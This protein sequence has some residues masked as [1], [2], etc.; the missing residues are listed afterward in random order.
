[1][2]ESHAVAYRGLR[3][4][5]REVVERVDPTALQRVAPA[6]PRWRAHDVLAHLVGVPD[7]VVHGRMDGLASEPWTQAQVD[8]RDAACAADLL[9]EWDETAPQFEVLLAGAPDAIA[10]Q[11]IFDAAAHEH[12]L[13]N[14]LDVRGARES[15]AVRV[16]WEWV[17]DLRTRGGAPAICFVVE[18]GE[19]ISGVGDVVARIEAPRFEF[20]RAVSGRR[21]ATEIAHYGWDR[22]ANPPLL[23]AAEIFSMPADSI[24]E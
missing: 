18:T 20:F 5:V 21:T 9:A 13:C 15:D 8:A 10:G 16:G 3:A 24:G 17:R 19:Q 22:E 4:R 14:A 2:S 11:A 23:L 7:D 1:M 12:D 6:T